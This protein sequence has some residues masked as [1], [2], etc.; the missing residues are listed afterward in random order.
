MTTDSGYDVCLSKPEAIE[1]FNSAPIKQLSLIETAS[2]VLSFFSIDSLT[3][4]RVQRL[5]SHVFY[6]GTP[7]GSLD[8]HLNL[9]QGT[10]KNRLRSNIPFLRPNLENSIYRAIS[11]EVMRGKSKKDCQGYSNVACA[12]EASKL[13]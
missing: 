3:N 12:T 11:T 1:E 13:V 6:G 7:L 4:C 5:H 8:G 2:E 10:L 9:S